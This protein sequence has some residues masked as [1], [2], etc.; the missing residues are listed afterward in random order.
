[1]IESGEPGRRRK[2]GHDGNPTLEF[3]L[4]LRQLRAEAGNPSYLDMSLRTG[5]PPHVLSQADAGYPSSLMAVAVVA[6]VVDAVAQCPALD[7]V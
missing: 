1:M 3:A 4:A 2:S 5:C 7:T 6:D